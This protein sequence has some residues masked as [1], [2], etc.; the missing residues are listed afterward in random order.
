MK[1]LS[2]NILNN[3]PNIELFYNSTYKKVSNYKLILAI[4]QGNKCF[5][6]FTKINSKKMTILINININI[7]GNASFSQN[8]LNYNY[9][10]LYSLNNQFDNQLSET[11]LYGTS[12]E[13]QNKLYFSIEDLL[14]YKKSNVSHD[15]YLNKLNIINN[16]LRNDIYKLNDFDNSIIMGI[17]PICTNYSELNNIIKSLPYEIKEL[18]YILSNEQST[19]VKYRKNLNFENNQ[20]NTRNTNKTNINKKNINTN[21][22]NTDMDTNTNRRIKKNIFKVIPEMRT[23]IYNLYSLNKSTNEYD[24]Q[25]VAFIPDY[26]TSIIM[27]KLFHGLKEHDNLDY[28][29]DS[30]D[31]YEPETNLENNWKMMEC[32]FNNKFKK[33]IPV[34]VIE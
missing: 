1:T 13:I 24:F 9:S 23:D 3:F 25:G 31:E 7:N 6:W 17:S 34:K 22:R 30:D 2:I 18:K 27:N 26:K 21:T 15:S 32:V 20:L 11:I 14:Y 5:I 29:E 16:I 10:Q 8:E 4:P 19:Y 12:F 28:L 33:W